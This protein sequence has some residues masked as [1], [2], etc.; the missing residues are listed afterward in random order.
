VVQNWP[1]PTREAPLFHVGLDIHR[2]RGGRGVTH[3]AEVNHSFRATGITVYLQNGGSLEKG[4]QL[5]AHES[6]RTTKLHDRTRS[7]VSL[8][9]VECI[10]F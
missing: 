4:Q 1:T 7:E 6:P 5:A 9:D 3:T 8:D 2:G 10:R